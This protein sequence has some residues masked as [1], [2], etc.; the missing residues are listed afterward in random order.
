MEFSTM[1]QNVFQ[2][3]FG[4]KKMAKYTCDCFRCKGCIVIIWCRSQVFHQKD[5]GEWENIVMWDKGC[6]IPRAITFTIQSDKEAMEATHQVVEHTMEGGTTFA[7]PIEYYD[8]VKK[9]MMA[10]NDAKFKSIF[11]SY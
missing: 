8:E 11:R 1:L 7:A 6:Y 9:R 5:N 2:E 3:G 4:K 10:R